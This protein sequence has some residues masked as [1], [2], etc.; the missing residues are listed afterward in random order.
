MDQKTL[1]SA[2]FK[3]AVAATPARSARELVGALEDAFGLLKLDYFNVFES[4][5]VGDEK[6]LRHVLGK[7]HPQFHKLYLQHRDYQHS[8]CARRAWTSTEPFFGSELLEA[9]DDLS[10]EERDVVAEALKFGLTESYVLPHRERDNRLFAAVL[11]GAGRPI[12]DAYRV[13]AQVLASTLVMAALRI[14][15]ETIG[16]GPPSPVAHLTARQLQCLEWSRRGKSSSDIGDILGISP[17][18]VDDHIAAACK[19]LDVRTR[20]QAVSMT[21]SVGLLPLQVALDRNP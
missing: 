10:D 11:V 18:T 7:P 12:D 2:V 4:I 1:Q 9:T 15:A 17:R 21:L 6:S 13:A 5:V 14:E 3:A 8:L 20:V 16:A 19:S